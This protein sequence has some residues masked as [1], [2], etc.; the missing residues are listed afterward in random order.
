MHEY[1]KTN[2]HIFQIDKTIGGSDFEFVELVE[3]IGH[4]VDVHYGDMTDIRQPEIDLMNEADLVTPDGMPLVWGLRALGAR[5]ATR[6]YGPDVTPMILGAA[7]R[8]GIPVGFY[9]AS[10]ETLKSAAEAG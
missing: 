8:E 9:G 2:K 3:G 4:A 10:E 6:V 1:C 5:D 7:Q